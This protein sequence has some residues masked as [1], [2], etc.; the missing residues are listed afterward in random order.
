MNYYVEEEDPL[1]ADKT[2]CNECH[3]TCM[4]CSASATETACTDCEE[5]KGRIFDSDTN[6]CICNELG[7]YTIAD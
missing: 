2:V 4:K 6:T 1:D 3:Y 7:Y 5:T